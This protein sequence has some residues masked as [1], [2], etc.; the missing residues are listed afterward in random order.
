MAVANSDQ[1]TQ[2]IGV[3]SRTY[4]EAWN[5]VIGLIASLE[6][7]LEKKYGDIDDIENAQIYQDPKAGEILIIGKIRIPAN[8]LDFKI[9]DFL[10]KSKI[11]FG[12]LAQLGELITRL[13]ASAAEILNSTSPIQARANAL[14]R[15]SEAELEGFKDK[16]RNETAILRITTDLA[17]IQEKAHNLME[18]SLSKRAAA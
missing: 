8:T 14:L 9:I 4:Q 5:E 10:K 2:T 6:D 18:L 7:Y 15:M 13:P 12:D 11:L 17:T 16:T 1:E 3:I